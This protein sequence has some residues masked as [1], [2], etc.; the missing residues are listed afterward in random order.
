MEQQYKT[1]NIYKCLMVKD[2][3]VTYKA[4]SVKRSDD[5]ADLII[6]TINNN[7]Q[8]DRE[9]LVAVYLN[10]S[11]HI[12]GSTIAFT[13]TINACTAAP[14]EILKAALIC[15]AAS[16]IIGHNHPSE[17][18]DPSRDDIEVTN[19]IAE[20]ANIIGLKLLDHIIVSTFEKTHYSF[21]DH[22]LMP[23]SQKKSN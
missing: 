3:T 21:E 6:E 2:K 17:N 18:I 19:R 10:G 15:N 11:N 5:V 9:Q 23:V 12:I 1:T 22:G 14:T 16:I 20:A 13:G 8:N 7:G 4:G